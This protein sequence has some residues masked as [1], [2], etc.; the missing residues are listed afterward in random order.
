MADRTHGFTQRDLR[1]LIER[2]MFAAFNK[3]GTIAFTLSE[4]VHSAALN[5]PSSL[6]QFEIAIP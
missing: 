2:T 3:R 1:Q 6:R 4:L 5:H